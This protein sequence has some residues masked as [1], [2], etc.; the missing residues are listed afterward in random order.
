MKRKLRK[1]DIV[2]WT[3]GHD[4]PLSFSKEELFTGIV[5]SALPDD[6]RFVEV[7]WF[8]N[9]VFKI[10]ERDNLMPAMASR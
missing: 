8:N 10:I 6:G 5:I 3:L 4:A 7:Y 9:S 1:G 2:W